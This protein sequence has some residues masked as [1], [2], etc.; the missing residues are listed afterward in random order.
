[1][2]ET[3]RLTENEFKN[4]VTKTISEIFD[5]DTLTKVYHVTR[6][7]IARKIVNGET[8]FMVGTNTSLFPGKICCRPTKRLT[9]HDR[10]YGDCIL[11]LTVPESCVERKHTNFDGD[12]CIVDPKGV[13]DVKA[14]KFPKPDPELEPD[15]FSDM[16]EPKGLDEA[17]TRVMRKYLR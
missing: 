8:E 5:Q 4:L 15:D 9:P 2:K 12:I 11:E 17:I 7:E 6:R 14:F 3:I 16:D 13:C 1:M 10:M